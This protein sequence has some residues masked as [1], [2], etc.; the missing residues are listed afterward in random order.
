M[1]CG[2]PGVLQKLMR[3]LYHGISMSTHPLSDPALLGGGGGAQGTH[4]HPKVQVPQQG[5][6]RHRL[7]EN[8]RWVVI[9][10]YFHHLELSTLSRV[11]YPEFGGLNLAGFPQPHRA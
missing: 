10:A 2:Y 4:S 6:L 1:L 11:L 3:K 5:F 9:T 7:G 8:I